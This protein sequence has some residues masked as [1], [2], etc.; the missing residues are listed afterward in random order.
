M[1]IDD[2]EG[3]DH[4]DVST[5]GINPVTAWVLLQGLEAPRGDWVVLNAANSGVGRALVQL[6]RLWGIKT[7]AIVRKR[8][9]NEAGSAL[10]K[11]ELEGLGATK[12]IF[13]S[14]LATAG[15]RGFED[16]LHNW[17]GGEQDRIKLGLNSL[18]GR[19]AHLLSK[20]VYPGGSVITYGNMNNKPLSLSAG[21]LIFRDL[22][23]RGFWLSTWA[24][25]HREEKI[26]TIK[27]ILE[28]I[29]RKQFTRTKVRE[30]K[31]GLG[32]KGEELVREVEMGL[33][34]FKG[35]KGVFVFEDED[36]VG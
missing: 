7:L 27:E 6:G 13:D 28:L 22:S 21:S 34:G 17:T 8:E 30:I 4:T 26:K 29:R 20:C 5:V 2:K 15:K 10:I 14:E 19:D 33:G 1:K 12:V 3:I 16:Q 23:F 25:T 35:G 18:G 32:T 9:D 31:W 24:Q 11:K 36:E